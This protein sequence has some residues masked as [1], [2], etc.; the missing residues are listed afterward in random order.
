MAFRSLKRANHTK[1]RSVGTGGSVRRTVLEIGVKSRKPKLRLDVGAD[2]GMRVRKPKLRL[3]HVGTNVGMRVREP[4]LRL[5]HVG[6]DA[7]RRAR[8]PELR[9]EHVGA[10]VGSGAQ[11][12]R[13]SD[14]ACVRSMLTIDGRRNGAACGR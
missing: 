2:V 4:K 12:G 9:L 11:C 3:E 10:D 14:A 8:K 1:N 6:A 7:G 13:L 5:E